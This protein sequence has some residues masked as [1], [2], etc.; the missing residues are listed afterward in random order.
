[1]AKPVNPT[2]MNRTEWRRK[3]RQADSLAA[4]IAAQ[5]RLFVIGSDNDL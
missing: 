3:R 5:P 1:L 2:L 4:Q